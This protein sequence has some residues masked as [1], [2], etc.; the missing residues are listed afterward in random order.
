MLAVYFISKVNW[1]Y[2]VAV[3]LAL[4]IIALLVDHG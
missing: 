1:N 3:K 2:H 4:D